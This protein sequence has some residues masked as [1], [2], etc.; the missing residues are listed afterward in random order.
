MLPAGVAGAAAPVS[1][2]A[3]D[4]A[5]LRAGEDLLVDKGAARPPAPAGHRM[6]AGRGE[7][8][9]APRGEGPPGPAGRRR[10]GARAKG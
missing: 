7:P 3:G 2:A 6:T 1:T 5:A 10:P 9:T 8:V 4:C